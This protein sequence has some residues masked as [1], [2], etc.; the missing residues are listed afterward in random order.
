MKDSSKINDSKIKKSIIASKR[1][2]IWFWDTQN[3]YTGEAVA[4]SATDLTALLKMG[5][6]GTTTMVPSNAVMEG[7][8]RHLTGRVVEFKVTGMGQEVV[9]KGTIREIQKDFENPRRLLLI[10]TLSSTSEKNQLILN[11]LGSSLPVN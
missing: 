3:E 11:K 8:I 6:G 2:K 7:L 10:A 4:L 5:G 1:V 9:L